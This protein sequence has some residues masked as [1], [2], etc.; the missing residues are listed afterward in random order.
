MTRVGLTP[1]VVVAEAAVLADEAGFDALTVSA[2][3]RRLGVQTASLYSHVR[4]RAALLDGVTVVAMSDLAARVAAAIA[5]RSGRAALAGWAGAHRDYAR[6]HPGRW[7]AMQRPAG[8]AAV[9]SPAAADVV[10]LTDAVLRGYALPDGERVHVIRL[11]GSTVNGF[12]HLEGIGSFGHRAPATAD[13]WERLVD[14][15]DHLLRTWPA[16]TEETPA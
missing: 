15:L 8:P 11:L 5:G 7:A 2:V 12:V 16:P 9:A 6:A 3:A 13:S 1:V 10:R 4:D 14:A